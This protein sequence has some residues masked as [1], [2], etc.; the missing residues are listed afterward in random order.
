MI[1]D[2]RHVMHTGLAATASLLVT[3]SLAV[4]A[5]RYKAMAFDAFPIFDP[6]PIGILAETLFPG[7]GVELINLWR[8]RQFEY[9]WLRT[10]ANAYVD[11]MRV[12]EDGLVYATKSLQ[13]ELLDGHR[14]QLLNAYL[15]LKAWPDVGPALQKLR[16]AGVR[17]AFLSNFT[18]AMLHGSIKAAALDG[19][20]EH[21]LSTDQARTY[22]PAAK[23]YQLGVSALGL[24]ME[25]ILFVAFGG[26]DVAGAKM[27]GY[28]TF[29]VNRLGQPAEELG[30]RP[31][32]EGRTLE[33]LLS[34]AGV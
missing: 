18:P 4:A 20:F 19:L 32:G 2:R 10:V 5:P 28:P 22:K 21:V 9:T 27:F 26:W 15:S 6:R 13:L 7:K 30:A 23:A 3:Q 1:V 8:I 33:D 16:S 17:L 12:T 31:D 29:W 34:F 11:F 14:E 25:Q 24:P